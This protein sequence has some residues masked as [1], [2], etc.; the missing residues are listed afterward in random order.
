[1]IPS[2]FQMLLSKYLIPF[3]RIIA[4]LFFVLASIGLFAQDFVIIK[5]ID[6]KGN[7]WTRNYIILNELDFQPG[8]SILLNKLTS[9]MEHNRDQL[10]NTGLFNQVVLNLTDWNIENHQVTVKVNLVE[11]WFWY[12]VPILELADRSFNEWFYQHNASLKRLNLGIRFMHINLSGN[13]DRLKLNFN[14]G[15]TQKYEV[16]YTFPYLNKKHSLGTYMNVLYVTYK[17]IP[18]ETRQNKLNFIRA[19]DEILLRRFRSSIGL[20]YRKNNH[21]YHKAF[22]E[23]QRKSVADRISELNPA[24]FFSG[25]NTL[26]H[27]SLNYR[28]LY[29]RV[30]KT[31]YPTQGQRVLIDLRKDGLGFFDDVNFLLLTAAVEKQIRI[32]DFYS[33][34]ILVKGRKSINYGQ[35]IPYSALHGLGF[36]GDVISGYQLYVLDGTDYAYLKTFQRIKWLDLEFNIDHFMP[37]NA[38]KTLPIKLYL[39]LHADLAYAYLPANYPPNPFNNRLLYGAGLSLDIVVYENYLFSMEVSVNHT[40]EFGLF[41]NTANTFE[42]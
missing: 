42:Y 13:Q 35:T 12:P 19:D 17:E 26:N 40:G 25:S 21:F 5:E 28:F 8:D 10:L 38:F 30:N 27:F 41:L 39:A 2:Q 18:F 6:L 3:F 33:T 24:Y 7:E 14:T 11:N 34:G 37:F 22:L 20:N 31:I 32:N 9:R 36:L 16:D 4:L 29:T 23:Y 1:M 15:F